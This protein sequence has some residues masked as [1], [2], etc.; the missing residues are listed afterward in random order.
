MGAKLTNGWELNCLAGL[1]V[2]GVA[3][4]GV[5]IIVEWRFI[6]SF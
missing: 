6:F 2:F 5:S 1:N 3:A 4:D